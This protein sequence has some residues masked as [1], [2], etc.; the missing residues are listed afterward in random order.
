MK[1]LFVAPTYFDESSII[2]GGERYVDALAH[3]IANHCQ[4]DV[5][6]FGPETKTFRKGKVQF[7]I[8]KHNLFKH[9]TKTN[10]F[11]WKHF[12]KIRRGDWNLIHVHQLCTFVSDLACLA[13][14]SRGIPIIGT[15]HGG[16]GAWVLNQKLKVY[17]KYKQVIGQSDHAASLLETHFS[18]RITTIKG[19]VNTDQFQSSPADQQNPFV[20]FVG[21]LLP[22]KGVHTL[23]PAFQ[24]AKLKGYH[25]KIVGRPMDEDY[26]R[27]LKEAA[28]SSPIEFITNASDAT[29]RSYY[30]YASMTVLPSEHQG[31]DLNPPELMGFTSLESQASGTPVVVSDAGPMGEFILE[32]QTGEIFS[33]GNAEDLAEK[34]NTVASW[35]QRHPAEEIAYKCEHQIQQ[36]SWDALAQKHLELYNQYI[37]HTPNS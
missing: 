16:G 31:D 13:G 35:Y 32:G 36:F 12:F 1:I 30:Q 33:A 15:D 7:H 9:F 18:D 28:G 22:H 19:G 20:L 26:F 8:Y 24:Q 5:I 21:R 34:L 3:A 29:L 6:S 25:L 10:P 4:L 17:S 11:A 14:S 37:N 2:G 27:D 23:I